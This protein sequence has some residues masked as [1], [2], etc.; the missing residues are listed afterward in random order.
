MTNDL[1]LYL[2]RDML[3]TSGTADISLGAAIQDAWT[4]TP[5]QKYEMLEHLG[6]ETTLGQIIDRLAGEQNII[7]FRRRF[8]KCPQCGNEELVEGELDGVR[9]LGCPEC[10]CGIPFPDQTLSE[11]WKAAH[12]PETDDYD[13]EEEDDDDQSSSCGGSCGS[14]GSGCGP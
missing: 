7:D 3:E 9:V 8:S 2:V 5:A 1:M 11:E 4:L 6:N 14:C 13:D 10:G 12:A